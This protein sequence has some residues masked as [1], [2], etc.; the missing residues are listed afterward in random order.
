MSYS[1][2]N[3]PDSHLKINEEEYLYFGGTAYLGLQNNKEF[4]EILIS[5][6]INFGTNWG[7]S[8][9]SNI[10]LAVF[11]E[12]EQYISKQAG[13][14]DS[15]VISSGYMA[16]QMLARYFNESGYALFCAPNTHPALINE[17]SKTF[18]N[19]SELKNGIEA[20]LNSE[21]QRQIVLFIDT[22]DF[23][24]VNFPDYDQLKKLP[25]KEL[26]LVADDSH[27]FGLIGDN[28]FGAYSLL[29][30]LPVKELILCGSLGKAL[31]TPC[32]IICCNIDRGNDLRDMAV[33]AGGSPPSPAALKTLIQAEKLIDFQ[34]RALIKN[35][36]IFLDTVTSSFKMTEMPGHPVFGYD[37]EAVT[38]H[39]FKRNILTTNFRYPRS[40]SPLI[41]KIVLSA[42]HSEKEIKI[43]TDVINQYYLNDNRTT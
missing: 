5:N 9:R 40:T 24:G 1:L 8:R 13:S 38:E 19:Y 7:A 17:N 29:E 26:I 2:D 27:G 12:F 37:S 3:S 31:A 30:K 35:I 39:L 6:I 16:G 22:I 4:Q 36:N 14:E 15:L 33:F 34:R 21:D 25:L 43:L 23:S 42:Y 11:N 18:A 10:R 41:S 20:H 28:G 32:G